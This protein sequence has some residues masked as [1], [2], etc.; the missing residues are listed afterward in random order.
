MYDGESNEGT[1]RLQSQGKTLAFRHQCYCLSIEAKL[2]TPCRRLLRR[3]GV[4]KRLNIRS[5]LSD[6]IAQQLPQIELNVVCQADTIGTVRK[7]WFT[8]TLIET[9]VSYVYIAQHIALPDLQQQSF[10][11]PNGNSYC[12]C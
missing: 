2:M 1:V 12:M 9:V 10:S 7:A 3:L 6:T 11:F 4:P 5:T 8:L